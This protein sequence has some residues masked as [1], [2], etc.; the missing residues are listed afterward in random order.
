MIHDQINNEVRAVAILM[1][2]LERLKHVEGWLTPVEGYALMQL[3]ARGEGQGG[4]VEIGSFKGR[5][6]CFLAWGSKVVKREK[7]TA[8][9]HFGGSSEHQPGQF[10]QVKEIIQAGTTRHVFEQNIKAAGCDDYI[11][12]I[13][14]GSAD[15]I[16][17]WGTKPVRLVFIDGEHTYEAASEDF[18]LWS[19]LVIP[20]GYVAF[21][22][23]GVFPGVTRL[24]DELTTASS[25]FRPVM[26]AG[27]IRVFKRSN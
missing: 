4:V 18:R 25:T 16:K 24:V 21:H 6:T 13:P 2:M 23:V 19:P 26:A 1:D 12:V 5:S 3:A 9:D 22:D 10:A 17:V 20:G 8:I 7:V 15:A 14:H 27:S 11:E